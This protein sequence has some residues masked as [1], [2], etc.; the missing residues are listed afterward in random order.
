MP[1]AELRTLDGLLR[2]SSPSVAFGRRELRHDDLDTGGLPRS[3]AAPPCVS[4]FRGSRAPLSLADLGID[5]TR[6][7]GTLCRSSARDGLGHWPPVNRNR[8][9]HIRFRLHIRNANGR[10]LGNIAGLYRLFTER[11]DPL[12]YFC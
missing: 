12:A 5:E 6:D 2:I 11:A 3:A 1:L 4:V 7:C 10:R 9:I 8:G